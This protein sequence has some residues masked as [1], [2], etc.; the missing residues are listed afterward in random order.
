MNPFG[1]GGSDSHVKKAI[2]D[3]KDFSSRKH[4]QEWLVKHDCMR[5]SKFDRSF[6]WSQETYG[7]DLWK[8]NFQRYLVEFGVEV[9]EFIIELQTKMLIEGIET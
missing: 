7:K 6:F 3:V 8:E 2:A 5:C 1:I 4:K 9:K